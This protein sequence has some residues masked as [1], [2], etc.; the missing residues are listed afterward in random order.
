MKA[1]AY[2]FAL[3]LTFAGSVSA[4]KPADS[5]KIEY[6]SPQAALDALRKKPGV[7]VREEND[8]IVLKDTTNYALWSITAPTHPAYPTAIKRTPYE[9]DGAIMLGM[10]VQCGATKA[11]C[12]EV[13]AQFRELNRRVGEDLNKLSDEAKAK[14]Q[15]AQP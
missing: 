2:S 7:T 11:V 12:D 13:V 10:D 9:R 1:I 14:K 3:L 8:W 4:A 5:T 6:P 15:P